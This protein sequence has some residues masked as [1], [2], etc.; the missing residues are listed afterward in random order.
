[1]G[2]TEREART[3]GTVTKN[4]GTTYTYNLDGSMASLAYPS[5][6]TITYS[7]NATGRTLSA[8]DQNGTPGVTSDDTNYATA[9]TYTAPVGLA[10]VKYGVASGFTGVTTTNTYNKR[11]QP[12]TL[13]AATTAATVLS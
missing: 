9:A 2:R 10:G 11:L 13:S 5:G 7:P 8:I 1:M 3:L 6:R 4:P 12:I